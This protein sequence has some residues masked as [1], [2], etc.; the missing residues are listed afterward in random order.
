MAWR[1]STTRPCSP[2]T[3]DG[4]RLSV[5]FDEGFD[6]AQVYAPPGKDFI[7]FEPMTAPTDALNSGEGLQVLEPG[8]RH[9]ARFTVMLSM[10]TPGQEA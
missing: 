9:R 7:C 4:R 2:S 6:W 3:A 8:Q 10:H 5:T 1:G